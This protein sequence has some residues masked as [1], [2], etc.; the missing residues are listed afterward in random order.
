[1][2][3]YDARWLYEQ[4][5]SG[6]KVVVLGS[7]DVS[8][9]RRCS[10][11][12]CSR[13]SAPLRARAAEPLPTLVPDTLTVGLQM[14]TQGF[15][16]GSVVGSDVVYARGLEVDLARAL[17]QRWAPE[18]AASCRSRTFAGIFTAG[19][20]AWDV[21]S[22]RSR[23][24]RRATRPVDF[25]VPY[26]QAS[27]GVLLREELGRTPKTL[28]GAA[29]PAS[30]AP[31]AARPA[32]T[33]SSSASGPTTPHDARRLAAPAAAAARG[34]P[35]RRRRLRRADPRRRARRR[36][37]Q[38][39]RRWRAR[40]RRNERYGAVLPKG[41]ALRPA[42]NTALKALVA[43]G[44]VGQLSKRWLTVDVSKLRILR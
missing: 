13:P 2:P 28:D 44:T 31:S 10:Q 3:R 33:P 40:S 25:S 24:R 1:M 8:R 20:K 43:D 6:T 18:R 23:S 9:L 19:A 29:R 5:P 37:R 36:A 34:P 11:S 38:L 17:A 12:R 35:L 32:R 27:Q 4:T 16:V 22:R 21:L 14:P 41:S 26:L 7:S 39:R 42:V 15:Q 30:S